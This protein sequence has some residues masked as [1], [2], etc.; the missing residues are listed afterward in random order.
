MNKKIKIMY[1]VEPTSAGV[2]KHITDILENI[3]TEKFEVY[4]VYSSIRSDSKFKKKM[5]ILSQRNIIFYKV[6][7]GREISLIN[8]FI[9]FRKIVKYI[10]IIKPE[11]IHSHSSKAGF[12]G[13]IAGAFCR[14]KVNIYSPHAFPF[15]DYINKYKKL[16]Y[17]I[18]EKIA[19]IFTTTIVATSETEYKQAID[20]NIVKKNRL[21]LICNGINVNDYKGEINKH[22][23]LESLGVLEYC[24]KDTKI[25]GYISRL[26]DQKDPKT[27]IKALSK[28]KNEN[29]IA[30]ICG[31]GELA[32]EVKLEIEN[33][34]IENRVF[35]LGYMNNFIDIIKVIDVFVLPSLWEGLPYILLETMIC[36]KIVVASNIV[37]NRDIVEN[38]VNG[39]LFE[40]KDYSQLSRILD[41]ILGN[42]QEIDEIR[43]NAYK[44]VFENHNIVNMVKKL[45]DLYVEKITNRSVK[46]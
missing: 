37:G 5:Q 4:F 6:D 3:D 46:I 17:T 36:K 18:L 43:L 13:R 12:L 7:M 9:A 11:I 10:K 2:G 35:M 1:I 29:Y 27:L 44:Y 33:L 40:P 26:A 24:N 16:L 15:N 21:S 23:L 14:T 41:Y 25:I 39:F 42:Y 30:I 20:N 32:D 34:H 38:E 31:D 8:D 28:L 22:K 45:E 19:G